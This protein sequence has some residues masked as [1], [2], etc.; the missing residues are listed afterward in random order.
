MT[1]PNPLTKDGVNQRIVANVRTALAWRDISH[2][3][4][5][6]VLGISPQAMARRMSGE[7]PFEAAEVAL[8]STLAGL[9]VNDLINGD[10]WTAPEV[11]VSPI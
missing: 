5:A 8:L 3:S 9:S 2:R 4:A 1:Q 11:V 7:V 6:P 10:P